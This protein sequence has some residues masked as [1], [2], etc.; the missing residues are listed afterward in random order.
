MNAWINSVQS[1]GFGTRAKSFSAI[2]VGSV[3]L[4]L[5]VVSLLPAQA[6]TDSV[7]VKA[8]NTQASAASLYTLNFTLADTLYPDAG[9]EIS[10][11]PGFDVSKV[12]IAG[13]KA[14]N[15]GFEVKVEGQKVLVTRKGRGAVKLPG[16]KVDV[17]F[18]T[19]TN[20]ANPES[21]H[22]INV[23]IKKSQQATRTKELRGSVLITA[24]KVQ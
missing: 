17:M 8:L 2:F 11:P 23:T 21:N 12:T 18:S 1:S 6:L 7:E 5:V 15:G 10:F 20:P 4:S 24:E 3:I 14:I 13:S 19:V 22:K 9:F 16:E